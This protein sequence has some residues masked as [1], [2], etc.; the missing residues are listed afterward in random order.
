MIYRFGLFCVPWRGTW[1]ITCVFIAPLHCFGIL[2]KNIFI[3][4]PIERICHFVI[5]WTFTFKLVKN[6]FIKALAIML[7]K[8]KP[9]EI[10]VHS[11]VPIFFI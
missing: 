5:F 1:V 10:I 8:K 2:S 9:H 3:H 11:M 4:L 7:Q 6:K